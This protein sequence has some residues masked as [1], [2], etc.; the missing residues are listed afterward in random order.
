MTAEPEVVL[1]GS[2]LPTVEQSVSVGNE[3]GTRGCEG[4][5]SM[6]Q[7]ER[8]RSHETSERVSRENATLAD[9]MRLPRN[10]PIQS[11]FATDEHRQHAIRM[12]EVQALME[13]MPESMV[14]KMLCGD[15]GGD[16]P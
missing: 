11:T 5:T 15:D 3:H 2:S 6:G 4:V 7:Q 14:R 16:L 10:K 8:Q 1:A 9:L 13:V 12:R